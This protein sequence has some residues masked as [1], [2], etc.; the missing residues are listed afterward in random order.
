MNE[1]LRDALLKATE[2]AGGYTADPGMIE[3]TMAE[4]LAAI[5]SLARAWRDA[6]IE[7]CTPE[8]YTRSPAERIGLNGPGGMAV[9][10]IVIHRP[11]GLTSMAS[12]KLTVWQINT[13]AEC[14]GIWKCPTAPL[15]ATFGS[16]ITRGLID[17][18]RA[19]TELGRKW[20]K[21]AGLS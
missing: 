21:G 13:L 9:V 12:I 3:Y 5:P 20:L 14:A 11:D 2:T 17:Y 15:D 8:P 18:Q 7:H 4:L 6:L 19:V 10:P 16:L 1:K